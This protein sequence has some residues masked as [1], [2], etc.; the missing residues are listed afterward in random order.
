MPDPTVPDIRMLTFDV[1]GTVVDWRASVARE[2]RQLAAHPKPDRPQI[3][4]PKIDWTAF[5]DAWRGRYGPSMAPIRDGSRDWVPLDILHR[6]SLIDTLAEFGLEGLSE[7]QIDHLNHAW[8]RLDPWPDSVPGLARLKSRFVL[9]TLSNGNIALMVNMA[10]HGGLPWDVILGAEPARQYKPHPH[11]YR[12]AAEIMDLAPQQCLMVAAHPADLDAAAQVG[13][14]TAYIHR[15]HE[16]GRDAHPTPHD[17]A[18]FDYA[19][20]GL[21]ELADALHC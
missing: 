17:G 2:G 4:W 11:V 15:P 21:D 6:E 5:A 3:D 12:S 13:F 16:H 7:A 1:F 18:R 20:A 9:A 10:K 19:V 14:H 8:H